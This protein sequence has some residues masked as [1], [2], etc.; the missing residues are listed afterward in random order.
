M[1][2]IDILNIREIISYGNITTVPMMP[3]YIA[4]VINLRGSVVPVVDLA[5]RFGGA[6]SEIT[7]RTSIIIVE[8]QDEDVILD[9]GLVVD[10]V[11]EVLDI[12]ADNVEPPPTFGAKIRAD[13]ISGM[14]KVNDSLLILLEVTRVLSV[15][16]LS[17]LNEMAQ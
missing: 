12:S 15:E 11:N 2:G 14:G 5:I 7:K 1:Y 10:Q 16:E 4:G 6:P 9:V 3:A 13:F 17:M 8:V